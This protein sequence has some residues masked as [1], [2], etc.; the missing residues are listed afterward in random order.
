MLHVLLTPFVTFAT[1]TFHNLSCHE[2]FFEGQFGQNRKAKYPRRL[3]GDQPDFGPRRDLLCVWTTVFSAKVW[4]KTSDTSSFEIL[5]WFSKSIVILALEGAFWLKVTSDIYQ[6]RKNLGSYSVQVGY[7]N[8][9]LYVVW[10][11]K[12]CNSGSGNFQR[13]IPSKQ[14]VESNYILLCKRKRRTYVNLAKTV[15]FQVG[16]SYIPLTTSSRPLRYC[17]YWR[18]PHMCFQVSHLASARPFWK[19]SKH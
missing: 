7:I 13:C 2:F 18:S 19:N 5:T 8:Y 9:N 17:W 4:S 14:G 15:M 1:L 11:V 6:N 3:K 12:S 16:I 10:N